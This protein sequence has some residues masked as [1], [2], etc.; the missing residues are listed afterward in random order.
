MLIK[1]ALFMSFGSIN[2]HRKYFFLF[3]VKFAENTFLQ[4]NGF[5]NF[6]N[7]RVK[8]GLTI[9]LFLKI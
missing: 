4:I 7:I 1:F 6:Y 3:W 5:N 8:I 9:S 2:V